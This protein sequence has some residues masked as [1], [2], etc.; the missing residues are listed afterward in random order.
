M[1]ET[2]LLTGLPG[3]QNPCLSQGFLQLSLCPS[4]RRGMQTLRQE[5]ERS[6]GNTVESTGSRIFFNSMRD[7]L[8]EVCCLPKCPFASGHTQDFGEHNVLQLWSVPRRRHNQRL[9]QS[10]GCR[11]AFRKILS[12]PPQ[13]GPRL[14]LLFWEYI[15]PW[16]KAASGK[17]PLYSGVAAVATPW[18][19]RGGCS[20]PAAVLGCSQGLSPKVLHPGS[21]SFMSPRL[22][23]ED[24]C[25]VQYVLGFTSCLFKLNYSNS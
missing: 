9:I 2:S 12:D 8:R 13:A 1:S 18:F 3:V 25:Q 4:T 22:A 21:K 10:L 19:G 6:C 5:V 11:V 15:F 24:W 23:Q 14:S 7:E 17:D 20:V 16:K